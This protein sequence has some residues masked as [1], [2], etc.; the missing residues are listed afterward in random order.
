MRRLHAKHAVIAAGGGDMP[1]VWED[2]YQ[3]KGVPAVN[4]QDFASEWMAEYIDADI[5]IIL[6]AVEKVAINFGK[7]DQKNLDELTPD[8]ARKYM[9]E[10]QFAPGS[11]LPKVE[12]A[13]RFAES[14]PGRTALI[15]LLE[16][17]K[18]GI[19]GETGTSISM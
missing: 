11:M 10:G 9:A 12:A 17:A 13:V 2:K 14:K 5:V 3:L 18:A 7:P 19:A 16:K 4:G 1:V 15:T 6:T 8:E